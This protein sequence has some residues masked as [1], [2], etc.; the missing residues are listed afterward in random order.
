MKESGKS[1]FTKSGI[2]EEC[3]WEKPTPCPRHIRHITNYVTTHMLDVEIPDVE[4]PLNEYDAWKVS[5]VDELPSHFQRNLKT[6][7]FIEFDDAYYRLAADGETLEEFRVCSEMEDFTDEEWDRFQKEGFIVIDNVGYALDEYGDFKTLFQDPK[8]SDF[9]NL[10]EWKVES[11]NGMTVVEYVDSAPEGSTLNYEVETIFQEGGC[12]VYALAMKE[13]YPHHN[14]AVDTW[15][16]DGDMMYNHVF[17]ID[18]NTGKA[19][20]SRGEFA[21]AFDLLDYTSDKDYN[22]LIHVDEDYYE[23]LGWQMWS[24]DRAKW[25]MQSGEFTYN[26][27]PEDLET[28][29]KIITKFQRRIQQD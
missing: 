29:K 26:D 22:G 8:G 25:M 21:S 17:T 15:M 23:D 5:H 4:E 24:L 14:I 16:V 11:L 10:K 28:V 7:G 3:K 1:G 19:Y 13:L 9:I 27:S 12:A 18:A 2:L 6:F 20:D